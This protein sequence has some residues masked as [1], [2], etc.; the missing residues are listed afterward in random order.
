MP[1]LLFFDIDGT[2]CMPGQAPS[3]RTVEAIRKARANGHK[4]FLSTGRNI[5]GIPK[6]VYDI[7]FD[8]YITNAGACAQVGED[9]LLDLPLPKD[10]LKETLSTLY[11]NDICY[12][13]QSDRDNYTDNAQNA[14]VSASLDPA[15]AKYVEAFMTILHMTDIAQQPDAPGYKICFV[16]PSADRWERI[17][18]QME[19]HYD[20]TL[21]DN[22]FPSGMVVSGELNR[23]GT[24]KGR[25]LN[26]LCAHFGQTAA[27]AIAFG[28]STNDSAMLMAAGT[29]YAMENAQDEVKAIADAIC[30][31][32]DEDGVARTLEELGLC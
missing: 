7:G 5:T 30:P 3:P 18:P 24:D 4:V 10:L 12:A 26:V 14:R 17:R 20:V 1:K 9:I 2:L 23:K 28:D 25:A 16:S 15:S 13:L 19:E 8:G 22:L 27:D 32:C 31:H 6:P 29:G 21:F 11:A